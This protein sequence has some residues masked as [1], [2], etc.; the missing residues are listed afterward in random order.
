MNLTTEWIG[1]IASAI[2]AVSLLITNLWY[3]RWINLVGAVLFSVYGMLIGSVPVALM[4]GLIAGIDIYFILQMRRKVDYFHYLTVSYQ[5]SAY[6]Q[7]F[8]RYY[9][10]DIGHHFPRYSPE[11]LDPNQK[12]TFILRNAVSVGVFSYHVEGDCGVVDLDYT[13]PAYRDLQ[14]TRYLIRDA[15]AEQFEK[16]GVKRLSVYTTVPK[17]SRYLRSLGFVEHEQR[18]NTYMLTLPMA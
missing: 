8:L 1:Y 7:Y 15:L 4:N 18:P 2:I 6:L 11:K 9:T 16:D 10:R 12:Y 14:N 3:F 5:Q 17:H 13:I